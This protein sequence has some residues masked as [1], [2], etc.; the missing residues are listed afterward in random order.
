[1]STACV[2]SPSD[3]IGSAALDTDP[4]AGNR[5]KGMS[6]DTCILFS[7]QAILIW[8]PGR[9]PPKTEMRVDR[10]SQRFAGSGVGLALG[11]PNLFCA[12]FRSASRCRGLSG[13]DRLV[14]FAVSPYKLALSSLSPP[15]LP[16]LVGLLA[17]R[18]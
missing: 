2:V 15:V 8:W 9:F 4:L 5:F 11:F 13:H 3:P 17:V 14:L 7:I 6:W 10:H 16:G 18:R 12:Q 1:M